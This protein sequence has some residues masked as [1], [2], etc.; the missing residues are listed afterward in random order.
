MR[1]SLQ[2]VRTYENKPAATIQVVQEAEPTAQEEENHRDA[3]PSLQNGPATRPPTPNSCR[4]RWRLLSHRC[5]VEAERGGDLVG[6]VCH[7][8]CQCMT[9]ETIQFYCVAD[10]SSG[11]YAKED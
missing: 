1:K 2:R 7:F 5:Q 11:I 3:S 8:K 4:T 6:V 9:C 10:S